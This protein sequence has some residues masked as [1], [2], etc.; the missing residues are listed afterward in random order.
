MEPGFIISK[1]AAFDPGKRRRYCPEQKRHERPEREIRSGFRHL[2]GCLLD[3][4][5]ALGLD[6]SNAALCLIR[7]KA[8]PGR[9]RLRK[10]AP[11]ILIEAALTD[12]M[13]EHTRDLSSGVRVERRLLAGA[14]GVGIALRSR[15]LRTRNRPKQKVDEI[16]GRVGTPR[17]AT[18]HWP[19]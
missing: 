8:G 9:D 17:V 6:R 5:T 1:P 18:P 19:R 14:D 16:L 3:G 7:R 12:P 15:A 4:V 13:K 11:I 10:V 2:V